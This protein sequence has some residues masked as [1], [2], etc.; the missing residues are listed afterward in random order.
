MSL[1][2]ANIDVMEHDSRRVAGIRDDHITD[3]V[4]I[5]VGGRLVV[6]PTVSCKVHS[7]TEVTKTAKW[8]F[9]VASG[10]P[11]ECGIFEW[12]S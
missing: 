2:A 11:T 8:S 6:V 3:W 7:Y 12:N 1:S 10:T 9:P 4:A 5:R